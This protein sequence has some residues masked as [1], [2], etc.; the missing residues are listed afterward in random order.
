M[1]LFFARQKNIRNNA[2]KLYSD[3]FLNSNRNADAH[4]QTSFM[5]MSKNF[6]T[7]S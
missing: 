5:K 2:R 3:I 7:C 6:V 4:K 1:S